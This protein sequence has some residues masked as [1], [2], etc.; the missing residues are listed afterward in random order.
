MK[1]SI[2]FLIGLAIGL[3]SSIVNGLLLFF[4]TKERKHKKSYIEK[5][6]KS[7][8]IALLKEIAEFEFLNQEEIESQKRTLDEEIKRLEGRCDKLA[9]P[10][11]AKD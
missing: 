4:A 3:V 2:Y 8:E 9:Q 11:S 1:I 5:K 7:D 10:L 6:L